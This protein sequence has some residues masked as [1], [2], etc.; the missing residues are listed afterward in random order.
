MSSHLT[1]NVILDS[2]VTN[3]SGNGFWLLVE[4]REYFVPFSDYPVF[5]SAT[6]FQILK[7]KRLSPSQFYWPELN[8]DIELDS[9]EHPDLF[10]L[11]YQ[12]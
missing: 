9:L 12:P 2:E 11:T 5:Y 10:P 1:G 4:D 6:V 3:I 8:I 7:L